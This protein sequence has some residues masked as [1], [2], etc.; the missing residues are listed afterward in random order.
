MTDFDDYATALPKGEPA[1][2]M[3]IGIGNLCGIPT[4]PGGQ[5]ATSFADN[6]TCPD[7]RTLLAEE[8]SRD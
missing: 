6:V 1:H 5:R 7:C 8:A 3:T 2:A 4:G